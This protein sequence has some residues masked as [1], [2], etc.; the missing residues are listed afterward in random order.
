MPVHRF[1]LIFIIAI[2]LFVEI[3]TLLLTAYFVGEMVFRAVNN[4]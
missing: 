2:V 1:A 4:W 3:P